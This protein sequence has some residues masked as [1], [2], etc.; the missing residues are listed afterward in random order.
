VLRTGEIAMSGPSKELA[1]DEE[2]KRAYLGG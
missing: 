2:I 1:A